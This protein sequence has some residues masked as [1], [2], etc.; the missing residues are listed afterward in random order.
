MQ[1]VAKALPSYWLAQA[2]REPLAG[3]WIGWHGVAV[4]AVWTVGVRRP[5]RRRLPP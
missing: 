2:G 1:G 5:R 4:L 3:S